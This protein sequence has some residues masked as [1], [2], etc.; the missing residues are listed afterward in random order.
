MLGARPLPVAEKGSATR[1]R[2][3]SA[4]HGVLCAT[5]FLTDGGIGI[6][7]FAFYNLIRGHG[8]TSN[9]LRSKNVYVLVA[10]ANL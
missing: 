6:S 1:E 4:E 9:L 8:G 10:K 5:M 3:P 2:T 7:N